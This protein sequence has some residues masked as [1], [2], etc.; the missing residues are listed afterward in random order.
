MSCY[1]GWPGCRDV[2]AA[3]RQAGPLSLTSPWPAPDDHE[4]PYRHTRLL[5]QFRRRGQEG[6]G[7]S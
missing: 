6:V 4:A 7:T 1:G 2:T 3:S 5:P